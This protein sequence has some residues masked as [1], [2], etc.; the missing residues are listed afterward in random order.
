MKWL[1][2]RR[3]LFRVRGGERWKIEGGEEGEKREEKSQRET[4]EEGIKWRREGLHNKHAN[5]KTHGIDNP[6]S[7]QKRTFV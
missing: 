6:P 7:M 4:R 5:E 1:P 3:G 2:K